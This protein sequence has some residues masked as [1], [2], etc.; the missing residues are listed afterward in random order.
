MTKIASIS[1]MLTSPNNY[2][3]SFATVA[4]SLRHLPS[5][6]SL[7]KC[8][9]LHALILTYFFSPSSSLLFL[10]NNLLSTYSKC[11]SLQDAHKLFETMPERNIVSYNCIIS[12]YSKFSSHVTSCMHLFRDMAAVG[13]TPN[14]FTFSAL[15]HVLHNHRA[16]SAIHGRVIV[17]GFY[18]N[19][20][21]KTS[22]LRMYLG[23]LCL[24][25]AERVFDEMAERDEI[26]WNSMLFGRLTGCEIEHALQLYRGMVREG[27]DSTPCTLTMLLTVCRKAEDLNAGRL[28]HGHVVKCKYPPDTP[29]L[30]ALIDMY[31]SCGDVRTAELVFERIDEPCLVSWN[32]LIAGFSSNCDGDKAMDAFVRLKLMN[33]LEKLQPDDFTFAAVVSATAGFPSLFY[34]KPLHAEISKTGWAESVYVGQTLIGMYFLNSEPLSAEKIFGCVPQKDVV[35]WTEM[36]AGYSGLGDGEM[37]IQYF[38][39]MLVEGHE[40]DS[41][42]L[43]SAIKATAF[44]TSLR[45]GEMFHGLVV[46]GG[47]GGNSGVSGGLVD[48]YAKNG[49]LESSKL[50]FDTI[51]RPDLIC[52]NSIIGGFGNVESELQ[53]DY[54]TYISLLSACSHCGLLERARFYWFCMMTDG[55]IPG[56]KHY[57]YMV[58]LLCRAGLL[59][60]AEE[61]IMDSTFGNSSSELWRILL[62]SSIVSKN[63]DMGNHAAKQVLSFEPNDLPTHILLSNLYASIGSWDDVAQVRRKIRG[64]FVEKEPGLSWIELKDMVHVFSADDDCHVQIDECR[65]VLLRLQRNLEAS[66]LINIF[67]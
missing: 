45:Q 54:I 35:I 5:S 63:L 16:G 46:K 47:Y 43:S 58:N 20:F 49:S 36:V 14:A 24:E 10:F 55:I 52:W 48:M 33:C 23:C 60:E 7:R 44:L 66:H 3:V 29:L 12:A 19:A 4:E 30:N 39:S 51:R 11:G 67:F 1:S 50:M 40:A 59:R 34:G 13:I 64:L 28:V 15:A 37:A 38:S 2:D 26:A 65:K 25:S 6:E 32:S 56:L 22:L 62:S 9:Q 27:L 53:P 31:A 21:V 42:S 17:L 57:T 61:M 41:F 18:D 8:R